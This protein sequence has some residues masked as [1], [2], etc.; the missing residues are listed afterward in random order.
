MNTNNLPGVARHRF[1]GASPVRGAPPCRLREQHYDTRHSESIGHA[2]LDLDYD[3]CHNGGRAGHG[4]RDGQPGPGVLA[5]EPPAALHARRAT[6]RGADPAALPRLPARRDDAGRQGGRR[7]DRPAE[8]GPGRRVPR[9]S[10]HPGG[11][12][13][14]PARRRERAG[15]ARLAGVPLARLDGA[16]DRAGGQRA[17]GGTAAPARVP[18]GPGVRAR[19]ARLRAGRDG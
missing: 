13:V 6:G 7:P 3:S 4:G 14:A 19:R 8:P 17:R 10:R 16:R 12:R 9:R 1:G 2:V 18:P 5:G 11:G 15:P